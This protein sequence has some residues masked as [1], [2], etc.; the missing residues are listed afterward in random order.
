[1]GE[2]G[3][4]GEGPGGGGGGEGDRRAA[5]LGVAGYSL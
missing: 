2:E 4:I 5:G 3:E 1:M